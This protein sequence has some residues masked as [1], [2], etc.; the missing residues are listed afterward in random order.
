[1]SDRARSR[2][3]LGV[4]LASI[5]LAFAVG[6]DAPARA[7]PPLHDAEIHA[8]LDRWLDDRG[9]QGAP[10][11]TI[12]E[13]LARAKVGAKELRQLLAA[14]RASYAPPP[15]APGVA[16]EE[17]IPLRCE[18]VD[19]DTGY[20]LYVPPTYDPS[21]SWPL[22][23]A[24]HGGNAE[25]DEGRARATARDYFESYLPGARAS[26]TLLAAPIT[27]RGWDWIGN[28]ILL[29]CISDLARRYNVD[30]DRVYATGH[31]MGGHMSW[32]C[33]IFLGDR[34]GAVAPMSGG[35]DF[36]ASGQIAALANL[37]GYATFGSTEPYQ[38][39]EFNR[40]ILGYM[41]S[42]DF[43]WRVVEKDGG[44]EIFDDE[45]LRAFE[46]FASH[47]RD[48]LRD[49]VEVFAQTLL[50]IDRSEP[51]RPSW[52]TDHKW[53]S[54]RPITLDTFGW[55]R[56][57]P[58]PAGTPSER[59]TQRATVI[60]RSR[61]EIEITSRNVRKLRLYLSELKFELS[62]PIRVV[63]NGRVTEHSPRRDLKL[64]LDLVREFDDRGRCFDASID[65]VIP[66]DRDVG[67]ARGFAPSPGGP[68]R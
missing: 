61:S 53:V 44:H 28:S 25:M 62:K 47:P 7:E 3:G 29:S 13:R 51:R 21:R 19:Y 66:T 43:E 24:G 2:S 37:P 30:P 18:H 14:G 40:K 46:W 12:V 68:G 35:Y 15:V 23:L 38:I 45:V 20:F 22:V 6:S 5:A 65:V 27:A 48:L 57:F 36:V 39:A 63:A 16:S 55:V 60:R 31:S 49:R 67:D 54:G 50:R 56:V 58:L 33:G 26:G 64:T 11:S 8:A 4:G 41:S 34:F 59:T 52:P 1:M 9:P 17:P 42:H 32:R 10:A